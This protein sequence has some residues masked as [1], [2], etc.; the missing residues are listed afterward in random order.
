MVLKVG[1]P[2]EVDRKYTESFE[3]SFWRR[4]ISSTDHM[5]YD[6][7]HLYRSH[8]SVLITKETH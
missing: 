6:M 1:T 3:M 4:D 8:A 7:V 5:K 2:Q